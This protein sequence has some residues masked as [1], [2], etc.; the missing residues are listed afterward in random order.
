[1]V[2]NMKSTCWVG[3]HFNPMSEKINEVG[4]V[5]LGKKKVKTNNKQGNVS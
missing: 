2:G 4:F 3:F 5:L 1:M